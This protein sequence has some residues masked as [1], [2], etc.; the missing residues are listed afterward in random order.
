[1]QRGEEKSS[2][3]LRMVEEQSVD[4]NIHYS[5]DKGRSEG[6]ESKDKGQ[7]ALHSKLSFHI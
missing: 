7:R 3:L 5:T 6:S 2:N 4:F 1:M